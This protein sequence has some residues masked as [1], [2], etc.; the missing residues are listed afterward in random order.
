MT[1]S[2]TFCFLPP[3]TGGNDSPGLPG[4]GALLLAGLPAYP[5]GDSLHFP[6]V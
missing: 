4:S 3:A 1:L 6:H 5:E 2:V